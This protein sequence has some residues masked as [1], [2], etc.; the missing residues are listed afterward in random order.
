M[1]QSL[2]NNLHPYPRPLHDAW[3]RCWH[4]PGHHGPQRLVH[5]IPEHRITSCWLFGLSPGW[6]CPPWRPRCPQEVWGSIWNNL[7]PLWESCRCQ[8]DLDT[9]AMARVDEITHDYYKTRQSGLAAIKKYEDSRITPTTTPA[10]TPPAAP[11]PGLP[12]IQMALKPD[13]LCRDSKPAEFRSFQRKFRSFFDISSLD[14]IQLIHQ[15]SF[16]FQCLDIDLEV[17]LK[18][19]INDHTPIFGR[20]SCFSHLEELF[21]IS[22]PLFSQSSWLLQIRAGRGVNFH[23]ILRLAPPEGWRGRAFLHEDGGL[24]RFPTYWGL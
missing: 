21:K 1:A 10:P 2:W 6:R 14:K 9:D 13:K 7:W 3:G 16:L 19:M 4:S 11:P 20:D 18:R 23:G 15:Q 22:Y 5:S 24:V 12:K 8:P 17:S